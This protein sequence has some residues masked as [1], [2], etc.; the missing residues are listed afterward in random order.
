M[1]DTV[2]GQAKCRFPIDCVSADV[3]AD[4]NTYCLIIGQATYLG[5]I[6]PEEI[7]GCLVELA[8]IV[9]IHATMNHSKSTL[10]CFAHAAGV[11]L[12]A[13]I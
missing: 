13:T 8:K 5:L 4:G 1:I 12:L 7:H 10:L 3:L 2:H 9:H 11:A 6:L